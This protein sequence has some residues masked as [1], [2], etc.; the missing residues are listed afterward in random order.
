MAIARGSARRQ[1]LQL[2]IGDASASAP[3]AQQPAVVGVLAQEQ[4][5]DRVIGC[6]P[7]RSTVKPPAYAVL[8]RCQRC[9]SHLA[10]V[11]LHFQR[12]PSQSGPKGV[13]AILEEIDADPL[14]LGA[15]GRQP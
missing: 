1:T 8:L 2:L 11:R 9:H 3:G 14:I 10:T 13:A 5:A 4:R 7:D 15:E 6:L 12:S